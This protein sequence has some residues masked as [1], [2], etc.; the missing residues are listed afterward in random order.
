MERKRIYRTTR[1]GDWCAVPISG[2][3]GIMRKAN[4]ACAIVVSASPMSCRRFS[5]PT[6]GWSM[7]I[8]GIM[9]ERMRLYG[10]VA[11]RLFVIIYTRR[12]AVVRIISARKANARERGRYGEGSSTA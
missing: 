11:G 2:S 6:V 4:A 8:A 9:E 12:G 7:M 10:R 5:I 1:I 3:N